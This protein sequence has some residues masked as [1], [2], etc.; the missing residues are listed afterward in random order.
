M[1]EEEEEGGK[2]TPPSPKSI[3]FLGKR[4]IGL[5]AHCHY[6]MYWARSTRSAYIH[7]MLLFANIE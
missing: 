3:E 7:K 5:H 6:V 4:P 2:I 1:E